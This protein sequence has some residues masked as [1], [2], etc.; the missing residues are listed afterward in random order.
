MTKKKYIAVEE[1]A[2]VAVV[3]EKEKEEE[4][5]D[6]W[7]DSCVCNLIHEITP[8]SFA[9]YYCKKQPQLCQ[10][11]RFADVAQRGED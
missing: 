5:E 4:E 2:A 6:G 9:L 11:Y 7:A 3:E 8:F 10:G 1:V